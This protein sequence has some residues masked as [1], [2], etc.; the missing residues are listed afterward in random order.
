M[1]GHSINRTP[2]TSNSHELKLNNSNAV[3]KKNVEEVIVQLEHELALAHERQKSL[4]SI[5]KDNIIADKKVKTEG[6]GAGFSVLDQTGFSQGYVP[7]ETSEDKFEPARVSI[8]N[9]SPINRHGNSQVPHFTNHSPVTSG[10]VRM[11]S[12]N[13]V[14]ASHLPHVQLPKFSGKIVEYPSFVQGFKAFV[15]NYC[16]DDYRRL[17]YLQMYLTGEALSV[18]QGCCS[19]VDKSEGYRKAWQLLSQRYG[20]DMVLLRLV[21][22]EILSGPNIRIWESDKLVQLVIKMNNCK[23]MFESKGAI[24]NLNATE[25]LHKIMRRL[26]IKLQEQFAEVS[27]SKQKYGYFATF[28]DLLDIVEE[29][30]SYSQTEWA[31]HTFRAGGNNQNSIRFS[32]HDV[33]KKSSH[34]TFSVTAN[35]DKQGKSAESLM[36]LCHYCSNK[37]A[38]WKCEEFINL[39]VKRRRTFVKE[40]ALCFNCLKTGHRASA[41]GFGR[42]CQVCR[43]KHNTLLHMDTPLEGQIS[44]AQDVQDLSNK[45]PVVTFTKENVQGTKEM[46]NKGPVFALTE[47]NVDRKGRTFMNI[48]P[49]RVWENDPSNAVITYAL[50]DSGSTTSICS[51]SLVSKLALKEI[52][53]RIEISCVGSTTNCLK[54]VGTIYVEGVNEINAIRLRECRVVENLPD[55]ADN[56]PEIDYAKI[57]SHLQDINIPKLKSKKLE[58]LLGADAH[59]AFRLIE[60]RCGK[61]GEPFGLHTT[62]GWSVFGSECESLRIKNEVCSKVS[63]LPLGNTENDLCNDLLQLM[64]K[65]FSDMNEYQKPCMS[66]GDRQ[67]LAMMEEQSAKVGSHHEI[68]LLWK[69]NNPELPNNREA[70]LKRLNGL[71]LRFNRD[72][73]LYNK[74]RSKINEYIENGYASIVPDNDF[75]PRGRTWYLPHHCTGKKF[76][77]VFD[78]GAKFRNTSINDKLL[79][80]PDLCNNLI[81]VLLRF[82]Q[83]PV[84][85]SADIKGMFHQVFVAEQDRNALR[86][87]WWPD[88][89]LNR[90][91]V[92]LRMNVFPFGLTCSPSCS[93]FALKKTARDNLTKADKQTLETVKN[94]FYVDDML[95]SCA[96][97]DEANQLIQQLQTLLR[98]GGFHLTKFASNS[99]MA[100]RSVSENDRVEGTIPLNS[101][102]DTTQQALGVTWNTVTD[103]LRVRMNVHERP[104]TRRGL[105]SAVSTIF[106]VLGIVQPFVLPARKLLQEACRSG[107][108]W[109]ASLD[110]QQIEVY[111]KWLIALSSLNNIS[112]PRSFK[113]S[114]QNLTRIE[115][116]VFSDASIIGYSAVCYVRC[117]YESGLITSNFCMGKSRVA[118]LKP[119]T[120][121]RLELTAAT[122]AAKLSA[123]VCHELEYNFDNVI[124]WTDATIVLRYINNI[125]SRFK[126]FVAN[127]LQLIY[128]ISVPKQWRHVPSANNAAD[129]GSRGLMP[130]KCNDASLWIN[131]PDFLCKPNSEWPSQPDYSLL[132]NDDEELKKMPICGTTI[133]SASFLHRLLQRYSA[134]SSVQRAT[135]W[136]LRYIHFL[137]FKFQNR[138]ALIPPLT[139]MLTVEELNNSTLRIVRMVQM[140]AFPVAMK[141]LPNVSD[142]SS[143]HR[144][145]GESEFRSNPS[146]KKLRNLSPFVLNGVMRMDGRLQNTTMDLDLK[147]PMILPPDHPVTTLIVQMYHEK[148][149]H[150][151]TS[152]ILNCLRK[153]FWIIHGRAV[154]R[155]V[156]HACF[157]CRFWNVGPLNQRM[158][159]LPDARVSAGN[160]PFTATGVDLMGP[161]KIKYGRSTVKR[162]VVVFTC[163]S[164]RAVHLE[165]VPSLETSAFIG[166][167]RRFIC[168]RSKP[169]IM[170]SDNA[171]NFKGAEKELNEGI[172]SLNRRQVCNWMLQEE[173]DW[174]FNVPAASHTGGIWERIIRSIRKC[175]RMIVGESTL[176]E[177]GLLT[178]VA[179]I[180][181][182][183]NDRPITDVSTDPKDLKALTPNMLLTGSL[184][185]TNSPDIFMKKDF[186]VQSWRKTQALA[187]VFWKRW[188][189]EYLP[190]LQ[191]RK[192]WWG[193]STNLQVGDLV[194]IND[195]STKRGYWPKAV[196]EECYPDKDG[197]VRR[198][199]VRTADAVLMRD[200]RKLSLLEGHVDSKQTNTVP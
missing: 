44:N 104:F 66:V 64:D 138:I 60:Q 175:M 67:A 36:N 55:I 174:K 153:R 149:G 102:N 114:N 20:N 91:P 169:K 165:I 179:E 96:S 69:M 98:S 134:Y 30:A 82:R 168:R 122:V 58:L 35:A 80:G 85:V 16:F 135:A 42:K 4:L 170:F 199:R 24:A 11:H 144:L 21:K 45:S 84:A 151:G 131:G 190:L 129:I 5:A 106:D 120:I 101:Q 15:E 181:R 73:E 94:N 81:G 22:E 188:L 31:Q 194:L 39:D 65:D 25:I 124:F 189:N 184:E 182:I 33:G 12:F 3:P 186:Y 72:S 200:V 32:G 111:K 159:N 152:H 6:Q 180:E 187:D 43:M 191:P 27:F 137:R 2:E 142:C 40:N 41:C 28:Q 51:S 48:L 130:D 83:D 113:L 177:F 176:D 76:R 89:D 173:I 154:V 50:L 53:D 8:E 38:L 29:A 14:N 119:I 125:N 166:A 78:C 90:D 74:Y 123:F 193:T 140:E 147:H 68:R 10:P 126:T 103:D 185:S 95:K 99:S 161:V 158:A 157:K 145:L 93:S 116:H 139:D 34:K 160:P 143:P 70:A 133:E 77:V 100:L 132:V 97:A 195:N 19:Y 167:F 109:D 7:C 18:I 26:P 192:Q 163:M 197:L 54:K 56:I 171:T 86:F 46:N 61:Y 112:I 155:K 148:E 156:L 146:F 52:E 162:Y 75:T 118:P 105:L 23:C 183:L 17:M 172:R 87:L 71:K 13:P 47:D 121:P 9:E 198:V 164:M 79:Q 141:L 128:S 107:A 49:V 1:E 136:W 108:S 62:L 115:L 127:R 63:M 92:D 57:Y 150:C 110:E 196:V 178:L 37:H 88:D 59:E 117:V